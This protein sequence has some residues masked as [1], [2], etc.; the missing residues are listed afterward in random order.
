MGFY[1]AYRD[2]K[3]LI[4]VAERKKGERSIRLLESAFKCRGVA[5]SAKHILFLRSLWDLRTTRSSAHPEI[6]EDP[7]YEKAAKHFDL[8]NLPNRSAAFAKILEQAVAFLE[9]LT[10]VVR[11][12]KLGDKNGGGC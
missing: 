11:S 6:L 2:R 5:G 1:C 10:G 8:D 9:F 4:P 7:R 3:D 12:G